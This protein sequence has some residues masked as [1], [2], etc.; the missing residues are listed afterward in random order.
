MSLLGAIFSPVTSLLGALFKAP[1]PPAPIPQATRDAA[2]Q[3]VR[4]E[5]AIRRR[6]GA[7]ADILTG[8]TGAE[9]GRSSVGKLVVGG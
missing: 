5:D 2:E 9:A 4:D 3:M 1:K 6:Q 8:T 7:A